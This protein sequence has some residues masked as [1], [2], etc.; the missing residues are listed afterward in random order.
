MLIAGDI[1]GDGIYDVMVGA[2]S[3]NLVFAYAGT[4]GAIPTTPVISFSGAAAGDEAG[5][6]IRLLDLDADGVS[7]LVIGAPGGDGPSNSRSNAGNVYAFRPHHAGAHSVN[8]AQAVFYGA[9]ANYRAGERIATGDIN[10]D[11]PNDLVIL[12]PGGSSGSG[13]LD[14]Y[15]GRARA[16]IGTPSGPRQVVTSPSV[17][18]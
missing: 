13:E 12:S 15:Y 7:D 18:R 4:A 6:A 16:S 17:A 10:R 1:T 2:P 3:Q 8:E 14:I 11:T 5:A 9:A